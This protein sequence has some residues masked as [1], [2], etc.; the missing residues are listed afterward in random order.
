MNEQKT[1]SFFVEERFKKG[2]Y[3]FPGYYAGAQKE[4]RRGKGFKIFAALFF[5]ISINTLVATAKKSA[6]E[7]FPP[8]NYS[9]KNMNTPIAIN[10]SYSKPK[11]KHIKT[12]DSVK[13]IYVSSWVAGTPSRRDELIKFAEET[14]INSMVIDI[15]DFSGKIFLKSENQKLISYGSLE[16]RISDL[17]DLI[18]QLHEKKIY[19]IGRLSVFQDD[20]LSNKRPEYAVKNKQGGIWKDDKGVSWLDPANKKTW[21]YAAE[22]AKEAE[23]SGFD[24]ISFD[25]IR[26]PSDGNLENTSYPHWDYKTPKSEIIKSFS[27]F[28]YETLKDLGIPISA[29]IFGLTL[30]RKDDL[31]IGQT[32]ENFLPYFDFVHPM[33]YP[34]HYPKGFNGFKNPAE[35]PYEIIYDGMVRARD[36]A[37]IATSSPDKIRPWIQDFDIGADYDASMIK[38]QKQAAYDTGL[39]SWLSWNASNRYTEGGYK[40]N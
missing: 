39:D 38:K 31:N 40:E 13:A 17:P 30:W 24:E 4:K 16:N 27:S 18:N 28:L 10:T 22:I 1:L 37:I 2:G 29:N 20:Y 15:K 11:P 26:F 5:V 8:V 25:Y 23:L 34:S 36:R 32:Y 14:E 12:P 33:V 3:S 19:V 7:M 9:K 21:E 6:Q 35:H